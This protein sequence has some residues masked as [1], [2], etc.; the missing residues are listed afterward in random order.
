[1]VLGGGQHQTFSRCTEVFRLGNDAVAA[2]GSGGVGAGRSRPVKKPK[3]RRVPQRGLGVA[4]LEKIRLEEQQ[5]S[6]AASFSNVSSSS[7]SLSSGLVI[8]L[9]PMVRVSNQSSSIAPAMPIPSDPFSQ[10][11]IPKPP[12]PSDGL[13]R[14][15]LELLPRPQ[16]SFEISPSEAETGGEIFDLSFTPENELSD[17]FWWS[18]RPVQRRPLLHKHH[19]HLRESELPDSSSV[20]HFSAISPFLIFL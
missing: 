10:F 16:N 17:H 7:V 1:M 5:R 11:L 18:S 2:A 8:P 15:P 13:T 9:P 12:L 19:Q 14:G 4:Q 6:V 3:E 20:C